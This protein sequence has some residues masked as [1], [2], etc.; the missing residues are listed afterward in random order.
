[1]VPA[2]LA[3]FSSKDKEQRLKNAACAQQ[4]FLTSPT[5]V[6]KMENLFF[7]LSSFPTPSQFLA[8]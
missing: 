7:F 8:C 4:L 2:K 1:M 3:F 6:F 5:L